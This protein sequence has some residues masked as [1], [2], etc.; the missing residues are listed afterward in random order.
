MIEDVKA[1]LFQTQLQ[2]CCDVAFAIGEWCTSRAT[3]TKRMRELVRKDAA[4]YGRTLVPGHVHTFRVVAEAIEIQTKLSIF[5]VA[6]DLAKLI[7]KTRLAVRGKPHHFAFI[8][9]MREADELRSG[10]VD[11][12]RGMRI[13]DLA[14]H[15]DRVPF[16][17]RP[18]GRDEI[19]EAIDGKQCRTLERR[20]KEGA[21]KMSSMV[22][23]IVK[24]RS[25]AIL[26]HAEGLR[27]IVFQI[28][29]LR[30]V[31]ESILNLAE[32]PTSL[33]VPGRR[34]RE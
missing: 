9:I 17:L 7:D 23:D 5:F 30:C 3:R 26:S 29:N 19:A 6:N 4:D 13:L 31:S 21:G 18:H 12:A 16:S 10:S 8:A 11:Y 20:N 22:F 14:Q 28:A 2:A 33:S 1:D 27:Q 24:L 25:K 34:R 32:D 15:F